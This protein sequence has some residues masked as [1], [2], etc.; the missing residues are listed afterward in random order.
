MSA[1][2]LINYDNPLNFTFDPTKILFG[3]SSVGLKPSQ[4]DTDYN[5]PFT[6]DTGF[7]YDNTKVEFTGGLLRQKDQRPTSAICGATYTN[8]IDLNWG[9]GTLTGTASGGAAVSG[10]KLVLGT[11]KYVSYPASGN[12]ALV[13]KGTIEFKF[14]PTYSGNPPGIQQFFSIQK[15]VNDYANDIRLRHQTNGTMYLVIDNSA[16]VRLI[17]YLPGGFNPVAGVTYEISVNFDC[18]TGSVRIFINGV[19]LGATGSA[20]GTRDSNI[21]LFRVGT[22][23]ASTPSVW[24]SG[25]V[26]DLVLYD[27]VQRT[28]N[29]TPGYTVPE[30]TYAAN[31]VTSPE[32][33]KTGVGTL[34]LANSFTT[35]ET[36]APRYTIQIGRSGNYLYHN[37][38]AWVA[39]NGTYSESN[40]ATQ[41]N[42]AIAS[43][44]V[45]GE[46]YGQFKI[47]FTDSNTLQQS[48]DDLIINLHEE[49]D[50]DTSNPS[51]VAN[52]SFKA[53]ELIN[54]I[55]VATK[56]TGDEIKYLFQIDNVKKW[57]NGSTLETSNGT[58]AQSNSASEILANIDV[59]LATRSTLKLEIFLH[60]DDGTTQPELESNTITYDSV[61][62]DPTLANLIELEGFIYDVNGPVANLAVKMRPYQSGRVNQG[63]FERY[64]YIVIATTNAVGWF[65]ASVYLQPATKF[66]DIKIGKQ[67]YKTALTDLILV[68]LSDLSFE[69]I[70]E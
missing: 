50:Y 27:S 30:N 58:Y 38:T 31:V 60:S 25:S 62:P 2:L 43:L 45:A 1:S 24:L 48:I 64:E 63:V 47:H 52:D 57:I 59:I 33:A 65:S 17:D 56:P 20:I 12:A 22:D 54:F 21:G 67:A 34:I 11:N 41:F 13:Q 14:T 46:M 69:L 15:A 10:G 55:E 16:G 40:S 39:S 29:Y 6:N 5:L 9:N 36:N 7:T 23:G 66:L 18:D 8:S 32:M 28:A 49:S 68:D 70:T 53:S 61:L 37:G 42:A 3:A 51:L 26:D 19:Q 35:T 4:T 44:P